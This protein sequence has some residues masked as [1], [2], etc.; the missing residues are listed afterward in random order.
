MRVFVDLGSHITGAP[1]IVQVDKTPV[2]GVNGGVNVNG[3]YA[4]PVVSG[5]GFPID[6]SSYVLDGGDVDGGDVSSISY[7]HLLSMYPLF[8]NVYFNPFLTPGHVDEID[9]G[10]TFRDVFTNPPNVYQFPVR[11]QTGR[12][13]G[14]TV[15]GPDGQVPTHTAILPMNTTTTVDRPGVLVTKEINIEPHI[16]DGVD[17]FMVYWKLLDFDTSHDIA[18]GSVNSPAARVL[19]EPDQ[20]PDDFKVYLSNDNGVTWCE[21]GLLEPIGFCDKTKKIRLA[22]VNRSANRIFLATYAVLF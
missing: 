3:K 17:N 8:S 11:I 15:P 19:T 18:N 6:S 4:I 9:F 1:K 22:F 12:P 14:F 16:P 2:S 13:L 5:V 7:A 10:A 20:E 21:V